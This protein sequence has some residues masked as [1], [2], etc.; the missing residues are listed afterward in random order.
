MNCVSKKHKNEELCIK[1][2]EFCRRICADWMVVNGNTCGAESDSQDAWLAADWGTDYALLSS[3]DECSSSP[4]GSHG[5][6]TEPDVA[7]Y[8]CACTEGWEGDNCDEFDFYSACRAR[9]AA[10]A[11]GTASCAGTQSGGDDQ[12]ACEGKQDEICI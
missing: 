12:A 10:A 2:D 4:C 6:C 8:T 9:E 1:I 3:V 5:T 7:E 11:T